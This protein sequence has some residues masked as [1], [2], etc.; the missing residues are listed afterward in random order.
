MPD[1]KRYVHEHLPALNVPPVR[2][3]EIVEELAQQLEQRFLDE[4]A[5]GTSENEAADF[6]RAQFS[7]WKR[8]GAEIRTAERPLFETATNKLPASVRVALSE[9]GVRQR[10]GGSMVADIFQDLRYALRMLKKSPSFTA[11]IV[12]TLALG[13]GANSTIFSVIHAVLLRPLPYADPERLVSIIDSNP[14]NGWPRFSSSPANFLDWRRGAHSFENL[15]AY[16][17]DE[18]TT[19]VGDTPE[20]WLGLAGTQGFFEVL[21]ARPELGRLFNDADFAVD[22]SNVL[23][24]SDALWR[25]EFGADPAVIGRTLMLDGKPGTII[26]VMGPEFQF[27]GP[28]K[29]FWIPFP[30]D[31]QLSGARGAHFLSVMGRLKQGVTIKSAQAEMTLIAAHLEKQYP[32]SNAG[33]TARVEKMLPPGVR[34]VQTALWVLLAAACGVLLVACANAANMLLAR[35][36]VRKREI[37]VRTALGASRV[38]IVRQLL[39]ESVALAVA[40]GVLGLAMAF[41]S[42]RVL[43]AL[44]PSL[45]PSASAIHVDSGVLVFTLAVVAATAILFGIAPAISVTRD[46]LQGTLRQGGRGTTEAWTRMRRGLVIVEVALAFVLLFGSGLLMRSL[47]RLTEV[48]PGFQMSG[49]LTFSLSLPSAAYKTPQQQAEF[50]RQT[51]EKLAALPGISSAS[52]TSLV[53]L[54]GD[55]SLW[56]IGIN[57]QA[58]KTSLPSATYYLVDPTYLRAMGIP[59]LQGRDFSDQDTAGSQHVVI[60]NDYFA[61]T[62]FPGQNPIGQHIQLGRNY[63]VVREVVGVAATVKQEGLDD[64]E[65]YEAYE[66]LAQMP[67]AGMTFILKT[68]TG[69]PMS[70]LPSVRAG[71]KQIDAQLPITNPAIL[72]QELGES[73]A[74]PRFRTTLL[75]I[76]AGL[77]VALALLGLYGVMS[78]AVTE[79]TQEIGVRM[80]LG[81]I[82]RDIYK[83]VLGRGLLLVAIG[84]LIGAAGS[85]AATK[86]LQSFLFD[87]TA[88]DPW[89]IAA[90]TLLFAAVATAACLVPARRAAK[91][92]PLVALRYQ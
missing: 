85:F 49:R 86:V 30:F 43:A 89:T 8:L 5:Q 16:A 91:V 27:G 75:G 51:R 42:A 33:W 48:N 52:L 47:A 19:I 38:R 92:D 54:N 7:D 9:G 56:T 64:K 58:N 34:K 2:E 61:R 10:K 22:K 57:G 74:L 35:A 69:D 36:A 40:G 88:H 62:L 78:Y 81:A 1:W 21:H 24:L 53:P 41:A 44:P 71:L 26:G 46:D 37:A 67:R 4:V 45:L 73:L 25:G 77:A 90:V 76:F 55:D 50:Y 18:E 63:S 23:L 17:S 3:R 66:P 14:S 13:I 20:R 87:V 79:Q 31:V 83:F 65:T 28:D 59:L 60:I 32:A 70:A 84:I 15:V 29:Q 6:A 68:A 39:T 11:L 12:L 82:E 80:A 72:E